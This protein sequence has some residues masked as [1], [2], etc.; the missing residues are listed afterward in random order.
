[1]SYTKGLLHQS[2]M[3]FPGSPAPPRSG[4]MHLCFREED[5]APSCLLDATWAGLL[6]E[7]SLPLR[8][9]FM[10]SMQIIPSPRSRPITKPLRDFFRHVLLYAPGKTEAPPSFLF[11]WVLIVYEPL[12][13][14]SFL[15]AGVT[16]SA[17]CVF[18]KHLANCSKQNRS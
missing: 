18:C 17:S 7:V 12:M 3:L 1:M 16:T 13:M 2:Q 5:R 4:S 8:F 11:L 14:I 9:I 6:D 15:R 10:Q